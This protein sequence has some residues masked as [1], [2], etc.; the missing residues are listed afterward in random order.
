[1]AGA[2]LC[3]LR[4]LE[5]EEAMEANPQPVSVQCRMAASGA[6]QKWGQPPRTSEPVPIFAT[7]LTGLRWF[8]W[9][10]ALLCVAGGVL[11]KWTAPA[12]FYGMAIPLLW[13]RGRLRLLFGKHHLS[14]A[15]LGAGLCFLWIGAAMSI[16]GWQPFYDTVKREALQHL[17][18]GHH[19]RSY[20]WR[21][22][23]AHPLKILATN[24]PWSFLALLTL[25][26]GFARL[27]NAKE[28]MLLDALHCW[29]WPNLVLWSI[30]PQHSVRHSFPLFPGFAGLA[31]MV[32]LAWF[33][34]RLKP[35]RIPYCTPTFR[36]RAAFATALI[37]W[38]GVKL[39]F[40]HAVIPAREGN[41][42]PQAKAEL[43]R[44]HVPENQI[45]YLFRLKD[46]GILFYYGREARR[47]AGPAHLPSSSVPL[48]CILDRTEWDEWQP[49]RVFEPIQELCDEQ[50]DPIV[51]VKTVSPAK[52]LQP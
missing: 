16:T 32:W 51:L 27:W 52:G 29:I 3:F 34:G 5:T 38:L 48:Y 9:L 36:P 25:R 28:R 20:P 49:R 17:S 14:S 6:M 22:T 15:A 19:P 30:I 44:E 43:L 46:E 37:L 24:L 23:L 31:A 8:W 26:P 50:G 41:R 11:T 18:P 12:F 47:L 13:K 4:A 2:I 39:A 1:V 45:L 35:P 33:T 21:E 7:S 42:A 40:V 10:A